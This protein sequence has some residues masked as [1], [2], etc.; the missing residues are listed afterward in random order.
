MTPQR[1]SLPATFV[2]RTDT[3]L[4]VLH[5]LMLR[6]MRTRFGGSQWGYAV[7]VLWPVAHIFLLVAIMTFRK[8]PTPLGGSIVLF[9]ATGAVPFLQFQYI[10]RYVMQSLLANRPLTYYPQVKLFDLL[11]SRILVEICGGFMGLL[12]VLTILVALDADVVPPDPFG[13][14]SA[15]LVALLLG[16][17]FGA[18]NVAVVSVFSGWIM[19]YMLFSIVLYII[20]G[21]YFLPSMLPDE[22]Y[23][24]LKYIPTVQLIE[25]MRSAYYPEAGLQVDKLYCLMTALTMLTIGL[26]FQRFWV[27]RTSM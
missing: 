19:G 12:A 25:W 3:F 21:V 26:G 4:Q 8:L 27:A 5:A 22:I 7:T 15:Y 2:Q 16:I 18:V 23:L 24:H 13:A 6:D 20:S 14:M 1:S 11:L 17:S 10:S 9:V